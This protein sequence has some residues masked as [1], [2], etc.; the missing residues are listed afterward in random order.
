MS[1]LKISNKYDSVHTLKHNYSIPMTIGISAKKKLTHIH[2]E[3]HIGTII[4]ILI[5][6]LDIE[7]V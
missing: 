6:Y 1:N 7:T 4:N 2:E 5:G 3:K